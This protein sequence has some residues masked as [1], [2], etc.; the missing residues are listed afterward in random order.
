[1]SSDLFWS[2]DP[3]PVPE[4]MFIE[5]PPALSRRPMRR[6]RAMWLSSDA[7]AFVV[8]RIIEDASKLRCRCRRRTV[9]MRCRARALKA[10]DRSA[11]R[12]RG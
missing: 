10:R 8:R 4:G 7:R 9:C 12:A 6:P 5:A 11:K 2:E 1:M 3:M